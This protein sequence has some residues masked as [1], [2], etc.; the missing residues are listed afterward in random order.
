M[1]ANHHL[2]P[3]LRFI[4][5]H[6]DQPLSVD[7]LAQRAYLS[8]FHFIRQFQRL[9]HQTPHQYVMNRRLQRAKELLA[10]S[11]LPVT[12]VCLAV[13]F[14][15]LGSFSTLFRTVVGW[16]PSV[17]RARVLEQ[18]RNPYKFIPGCMCAMFGLHPPSQESNFQEAKA[19]QVC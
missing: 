11:D 13:G 15:S 6:L 19:E 5:E 7:E 17:Y 4:D 2:E 3:I 12:E 18:R 10:N 9:V 16:S 8:R 1:T 14:E